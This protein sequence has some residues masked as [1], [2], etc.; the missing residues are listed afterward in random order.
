MG[1]GGFEPPLEAVRFINR[2]MWHPLFNEPRA[3]VIAILHYGPNYLQNNISNMS[4]LPI[5]AH[6][7]HSNGIYL[8]PCRLT[9]YLQNNKIFKNI[10]L[11]QPLLAPWL[12]LVECTTDNREVP[13]SN[14]LTPEILGGAT[15][16][17]KIDLTE[18]SILSINL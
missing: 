12:S 10:L 1:P 17:F 13:S 15:I 16:F 18:Y 11:L 4:A 3:P 14:G 8:V 7:F 5:E 2:D 6:K 9:Y